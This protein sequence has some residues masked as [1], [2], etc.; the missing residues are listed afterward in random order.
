MVLDTKLINLIKASVK[1]AQLIGIDSLVIEESGIRAIDD[2]KTVL[3]FQTR[4][5]PELPFNSIA[6]S[7]VNIF[8]ARIAVVETRKNM[9]IEA[10]LNGGSVQSL[11][12]KGDGTKVDYR[13]ANSQTVRAPTSLDK[14]GTMKWEF[15]IPLNPEAV[16]MMVKAQTAMGSD[17]VTIVSNQDGVAFEMI[18]NTNDVFSYNVTNQVESLFVGTDPSFVYRYPIKTLL[19]LFKQDT[20]GTFEIANNGF[21]KYAVNGLDVIVLPKV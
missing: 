2:D 14:T 4:N 15:R 19:S 3:I 12:L 9:I 1:T 5:I 6:I 21:L 16:M 18:D 20:E 13:C 17:L 8:N 10:V 7:R 11:L